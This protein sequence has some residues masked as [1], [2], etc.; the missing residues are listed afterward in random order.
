MPQG[1]TRGFTVLELIIVIAI[2]AVLAVIL[3]IILSPAELISRTRDSQ[4]LSDLRSLKIAIDLLSA[5]DVVFDPDG[6]NYADSCAGESAQNVFFSLPSEEGAP[7]LPSGWSPAQVA[8]ADIRNIDGSGWLPLHFANGN[9]ALPV[10]PVDPINSLVRNLYYTYVCSRNPHFELTARMESTRHARHGSEDKASTDGGDD[11]FVYETGNN[12]QLNPMAPLG[13]WAFD[14]ASG[15]V[16]RDGSRYQN[17]A[18]LVD[19]SPTNGDGAT[20]PQWL[21]SSSCI[22]G[23]CVQF[24]GTDD[25]VRISSH[26]PSFANK[27]FRDFTVIFWLYKGQGGTP[28]FFMGGTNSS[29]DE[30][31]V[32]G[33]GGGGNP[34]QLVINSFAQSTGTPANEFEDKWAHI[35]IVKKGSMATIYVDGAARYEA[36]RAQWAEINFEGSHLLWGA[37]YSSPN[38]SL[39]GTSFYSGRMDE[40]FLYDR[41]LQESEIKQHVRTP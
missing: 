27:I 10:L 9:S 24:D 2:M 14:D 38:G 39:S 18:T 20:P 35:A 33:T 19:A 15:A 7:V 1:F 25:Y 5:N 37:A 32:K 23:S 21:S 12:L 6:P 34:L 31:L 11:P 28:T 4:R 3:T 8:L 40:A 17:H 13:M 16:A 30:F 26:F 41:A 22:S 29:V 36:A